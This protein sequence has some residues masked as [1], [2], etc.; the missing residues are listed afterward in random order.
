MGFLV[1]LSL[2]CEKLAE[3][4]FCLIMS[5]LEGLGEKLRWKFLYTSYYLL[6]YLD[7]NG[8]KVLYFFAVIRLVQFY[9]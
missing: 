2:Y 6:G 9:L 3:F 7:R 4:D 8:N 1:L 5:K